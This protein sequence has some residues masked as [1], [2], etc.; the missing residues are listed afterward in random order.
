M[1]GRTSSDRPLSRRAVLGGLTATAVT[2]GLAACAP[3]GSGGGGASTTDPGSGGAGAGTAQRPTHVTFAGVE[4]DLPGT[5]DGI[6]PG[7][8]SYPDP[9][10][11][12][13]GFP[14]PAGD[15]IT[16][17]MQGNPNDTPDDKNENFQNIVSQL[18]SE[19]DIVYGGFGEYI[20][21]FQVTMAGADI[22]DLCMILPVPQLPKLLDTHFTDLSDVLGGDAVTK[23]PGL[24]NIPAPSWDV[25]TVN[26]KLFGIPMPTPPAGYVI[27]ARSDTLAARGISDPS[28]IQLRDGQDFVDLLDQLTDQ[29]KKEFAMGADPLIWLMAIMKQMV[30]TP[31][32]WVEQDGTFVHENES[33]QM[34]DA[35][36]EAAKI[37]QAGYLHPNSFSDPGQNSTWWK[38]GVTGLYVQGFSGWNRQSREDVEWDYVN[39]EVPAWDGGEPRVHKSAP[40]YGAFTAFAKT[41]GERLE[42]LLQVADF[43][44]SPFG[45]QQFIDL[46]Y[47]VEDYSY[48][49]RD[50]E[51]VKLEDTPKIPAVLRYCGGNY[52]SVLYGVGEEESVRTQHD[53]LSRVIPNGVENAANGL[54]S[55]TAVTKAATMSAEMSDVQRSILQGNDPVSRWDEFVKRWKSRVGDAMAAEYG[56]AKSAA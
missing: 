41:S 10:I 8:F 29:D 32:Q 5:A 51:P 31:N 2:A 38:A 50:G 1:R 23:Y 53:Y 30:G 39:V 22:P 45:T 7:V 52:A 12:R 43:L 35:L 6:P 25:A 11:Q 49:R 28:S 27:T 18:G 33:E 17:L 19:L 14:L 21:K 24:A 54:Y 20:N 13:D 40:G 37:V 9:P 48:E 4:P 42:Q 47:G 56:E 26:G 16:A 3:E 15:P 36:N 34:K 44:A 55:E 46:N